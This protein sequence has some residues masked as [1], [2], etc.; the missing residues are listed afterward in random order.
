HASND[1]FLSYLKS[2]KEPTIKDATWMGQ[3][4]LY[5]GVLDN[6]KNRDGFAS[7][8]CEAAKEHSASPKMVKVVDVA[9]V[10]S[11]GKFVELGKAYC[12]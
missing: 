2:D 12:K 4:N 7:Y 8:V 10:K 9:K 3:S 1:S 11:T 5:V 6:G